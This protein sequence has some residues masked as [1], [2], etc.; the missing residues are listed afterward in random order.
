MDI[1][2]MF[3]SDAGMAE[4]EKSLLNLDSE[5]EFKCRHCG[6]CCTHQDTILLTARDIFRIARRQNRPPFEVVQ[7]YT[8]VYL[9]GNSLVPVVHL[10]SNGPGGTC[11]L[12]GA[13]K[14]CTVHDC[15]PTVC[16]L[17]PLGRVLVNADPSKPLTVDAAKQVRY[18][19]NDHDCGSHKKKHTVRE[20][21]AQF[22]IPENDDF[23][24][25]WN[26]CI[27]KISETVRSTVGN[28]EMV[29]PEKLSLNV[30]NALWGKIFPLLYLY[31]DF[32]QDFMEQFTQ[33]VEIIE[34]VLKTLQK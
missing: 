9:G 27:L 3:E 14:R 33:N 16:A 22:G 15:K 2:K 32:H 13:D 10:L 23:F 6:K 12:L 18:I 4:F 34:D 31:Y 26:H 19:L 21:L 1:K 25:R 5:F 24:L 30:R 20:W 7:D 8:E 11:P 28:G 17:Y 29:N